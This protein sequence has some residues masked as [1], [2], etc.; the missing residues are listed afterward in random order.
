MPVLC[1]W[2]HQR[3]CVRR[4]QLA[5]GKSQS[6]Q[7]MA[8]NNLTHKPSHFLT[9]PGI[10][11]TGPWCINTPFTHNR[12]SIL[13][14]SSKRRPYMSQIR[15]SGA[16]TFFHVP[17]P[18]E[19]NETVQQQ[20]FYSGKIVICVYLISGCGILITYHITITYVG[21]TSPVWIVHRSHCGKCYH[22]V[23][24]SYCFRYLQYN[25][26]LWC[27]DWH[28]GVSQ[29]Q[30]WTPLIPWTSVLS[31]VYDPMVLDQIPFQEY[32]RYDPKR[33]ETLLLEV[34]L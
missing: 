33:H 4:F 25:R 30:I 23:K 17:H 1:A 28:H 14:I 26:E 8:L 32:P 7:K 12:H 15:C 24:A 19:N 27:R 5:W 31:W 6:L 9:C 21:T 10:G 3:L 29:G 11:L 20:K 22:R 34:V 2:M 13:D 16:A 18:Y